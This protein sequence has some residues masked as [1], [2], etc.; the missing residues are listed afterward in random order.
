[1]KK[2]TYRPGKI[3]K[4]PVYTKE[5]MHRPESAEKY[6]SIQKKVRVDRKQQVGMEIVEFYG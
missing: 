6:R 4:I 3:E 2:K 5:S 1:M